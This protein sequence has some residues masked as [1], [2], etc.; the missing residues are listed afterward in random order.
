MQS[1]QRIHDIFFPRMKI[2]DYSIVS[3][4]QNCFGQPIK[5]DI[6]LYENIQKIT[7]GQGNNYTTVCLVNYLHL[8]ISIYLN[9]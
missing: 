1:E 5:N 4:G 6:R 9:N 2:K 3:N 7:M 8:M